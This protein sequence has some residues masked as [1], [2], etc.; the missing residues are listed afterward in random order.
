M[1][2]KQLEASVYQDPGVAVTG[3]CRTQTS[4]TT[5]DRAP[6]PQGPGPEPP[7]PSVHEQADEGG[8]IARFRSGDHR[9]RLD[10]GGA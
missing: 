4:G 7:R 2:A 8:R 3:L 6:D 9:A 5:R 1:P 10:R